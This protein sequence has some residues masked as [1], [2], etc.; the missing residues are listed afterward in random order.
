MRSCRW[1]SSRCGRPWAAS[2]ITDLT[3]PE[4][5][6]DIDTA[7]EQALGLSMQ[8]Y[9]LVFGQVHMVA[10]RHDRY[11]EHRKKLGEAW[12]LREQVEQ[13]KALDGVYSEEELRRVKRQEKTNELQ[14]LAEQVASDRM[15]G[16]L[17]VL[18]RRIGIRNQWRDAL[19]SE[20][21]DKVKDED[22][23][24]RMLLEHD[25]NKVMREGEIDEIRAFSAP[26]RTTAS[27]PAA[28][29]STRS[30]WSARRKRSRSAW[31][32]ATP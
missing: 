17:G 29:W 20:K 12:L 1:S 8:R 26:S 30:R 11:D 19:R 18:V 10:I 21:F 3:G 16:E 7:V 27:R 14:L 15:E 28:T 32:S 5:R 2:S 9:G 6:R 13:E 24:G 25:K 22:E 23:L 4:V 31:N